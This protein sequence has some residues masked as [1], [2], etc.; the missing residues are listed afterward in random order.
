MPI[1]VGRRKSQSETADR[2]DEYVVV[3]VVGVLTDGSEHHQKR[4]CLHFGGIEIG[5]NLE[6][7]RRAFIDEFGAAQ[8]DFNKAVSTV[9]EMNDGVAFPI[10]FVAEVVDVA[11]KSISYNPQ[12]AYAE[13][14]KKKAAGRQI[15][16]EILR[17][18]SQS[19]CSDGRID[20]ITGV[21]RAYGRFGSKVRV[22][23]RHVFNHEDLLQGI[24]VFG[25]RLPVK[26]FR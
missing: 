19:C 2:Y 22:P 1:S 6:K 9:A 8:F 18:D 23:G 11:V 10:V 13:R 16:E 20:E 4:R 25:Q 7:V 26:L 15:I 21:G 17:A 24:N 5:S 14:F 12:I 3:A